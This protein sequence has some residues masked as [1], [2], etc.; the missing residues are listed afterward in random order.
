MASG[1]GNLPYPGKVYNPFDIL[2]AE[3]LNEDVANIEALADGSGI[4]DGA[5]SNTL[6]KTGAG[7][8]GGSWT[9]F[10]PTLSGRF[11]NSK[12]TKTCTYAQIG[13]TVYVKLQLVANAA[14][15][16]DG[17]GNPNFTI[18]V[19]SILYPTAAL[20][21]KCYIE[22]VG[23]SGYTG[24]VRFTNTT[25]LDIAIENVG[26]TYPVTAAITDTAPFTWAST[27]VIFA[28]FTYEAA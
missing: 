25:T 21:S 14:S 5:I 11:N 7:E 6:L 1:T 19:T 24:V 15:P 12:W 22:D 27:D 10:T 9:T 17:S 4:G 26:G 8:P 13:K 28:I 16:M 3:E 18:P 23:S 2:T 20:I